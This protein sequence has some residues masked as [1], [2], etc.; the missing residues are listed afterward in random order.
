MEND[1]DKY[2]MRQVILE[3]PNDLE[4][5]KKFTKNIELEKKEYSN[6]IICGMGGS[7][8]PGEVL[9]AYL[10]QQ[11]KAFPL[12]FYVVRNY[13]LPKQANKESLIF[14]SSYS[15]NTEETVSCFHEALKIGATIVS[16]SAGGEVEEIASKNNTPHVKYKI[17]YHHFQPRYS[18]TYAFVAMNEVLTKIGLSDTIPKLPDFD[19]RSLEVQGEEL[20]KKINDKTPIIYASYGMKILAKIW[21]IKIN[22][23]SKAPAFWNYFPELDHNEINGFIHPQAKFHVIMLRDEK[24]HPRNNKRIEVTANLYKKFGVGVTILD[25]QGDTFV[26]QLIWS[27]VYADWVAYYLAYEYK[28]DPTPVEMVELLKKQLK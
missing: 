11:E 18:L 2:N 16:F 24:S 12:P 5:S 26:Q 7:G 6:L 4:L 1:F 14:I 21:K 13:S 10:N 20:A 22:E 19:A 27:S 9:R 25:I 8:H 15:G 3:Y 23:N 17:N 28:Q